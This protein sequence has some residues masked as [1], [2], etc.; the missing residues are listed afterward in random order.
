MR[1]LRQNQGFC[2]GIVSVLAAAEDERRSVE[3]RTAS[4]ASFI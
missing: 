1:H 3:A 4:R 2:V